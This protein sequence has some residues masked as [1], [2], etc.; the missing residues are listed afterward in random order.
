M[1]FYRKTDLSKDAKRIPEIPVTTWQACVT[2][3]LRQFCSVTTS[4]YYCDMDENSAKAIGAEA[5]KPESRAVRTSI[6]AVVTSLMRDPGLS[7][8]LLRASR[9]NWRAENGGVLLLLFVDPPHTACYL[10]ARRHTPNPSFLSRRVPGS[11]PK[12]DLLPCVQY[13]LSSEYV[14]KRHCC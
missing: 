12:N 7:F 9:L 13:K 6:V 10:L 14:E 2:H 5:A 4:V 3:F 1:D 11:P 8:L